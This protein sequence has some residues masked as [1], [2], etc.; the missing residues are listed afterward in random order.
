MSKRESIVAHVVSELN[1]LG[2]VKTITR[3]PKAI[4]ELSPNSFPHVLVET[5]NETREHASFSDEQKRVADLDIT[6]NILVHGNNRDQ[7]RNTVI[8]AIEEQLELDPSLG[9]VCFDSYVTDVVIREIAETAPYGQAAMVIRA[10]Y[11]YT[12]GNA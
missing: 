9:G 8:E 5:T 12:R 1:S 3:E 2:A 7:K 4:E 11:Y 10:R 6:I